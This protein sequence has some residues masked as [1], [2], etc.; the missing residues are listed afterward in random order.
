MSPPPV[1]A[2]IANTRGKFI[3]I[4]SPWITAI[5]ELGAIV[6]YILSRLAAIPT[7][8]SNLVYALAAVGVCAAALFLLYPA[9]SG[10]RL[11][12]RLLLSMIAIFV[13]GVLLA[14]PIASSF[15]ST[16]HVVQAR[17]K[18]PVVVNE[19]ATLDVTLSGALP[20]GT[21]LWPL[22]HVD[23]DPENI[24]YVPSENCAINGPGYTC[25]RLVFGAARNYHV[26]L[27]LVNSTES[28]ELLRAT[29]ADIDCKGHLPGCVQNAAVIQTPIGVSVQ[30]GQVSASVTGSR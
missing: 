17:W 7:G 5:S 22:I 26:E 21:I 19:G 13:G 20:S 18:G 6:G 10:T 11:W 8:L 25:N 3:D 28:R 1:A 23:T 2:Q 9:P 4:A 16:L 24:Y 29:I 12:G 30:G 15:K 27:R 14:D